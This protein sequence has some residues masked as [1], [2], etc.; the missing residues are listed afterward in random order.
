MKEFNTS[1]KADRDHEYKIKV[2]TENTG[3]DMVYI[4][5]QQAG[6]VTLPIDVFRTFANVFN[7]VF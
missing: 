3:R 1:V 4:S 6:D 2:Y 7:A 5:D